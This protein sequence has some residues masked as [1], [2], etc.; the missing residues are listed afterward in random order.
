MAQTQKPTPN[1]PAPMPATDAD[2]QHHANLAPQGRIDLSDKAPESHFT[3]E[4]DGETVPGI[5]AS[6][7][8]D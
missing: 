3:P 5:P 6:A 7:D 8:Q 2:R 4:G 1:E